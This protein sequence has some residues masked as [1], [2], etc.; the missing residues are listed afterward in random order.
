M[1]RSLVGRL[2]NE[3]IK[4]KTLFVCL[5]VAG[6]L[7]V[8]QAITRKA[9]AQEQGEKPESDVKMT[10]P[11]GK[12]TPWA[13]MKSAAAKVGGKAYNATFEFEDGKWIYGVMVVN[14]HKMSE[15]E[16]D[17]TTGKVGDVESI[18]PAKEAKEVQGELAKALKG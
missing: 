6:A 18:D 3:M 1:R 7:L 13:A 16:I 11:R 5:A 15:V 12:V 17:A 9:F 14:N 4:S 10:A 8:G 2:V